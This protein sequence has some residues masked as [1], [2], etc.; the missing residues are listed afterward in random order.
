MQIKVNDT[1]HTLEQPTHLSVLL[2]AFYPKQD[3][4]A[5]AINDSVIP[6][7]LWPQTQLTANDQVTIFNAIAGG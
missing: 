5:V 4:L 6:R 2:N 1:T 7:S 3:G